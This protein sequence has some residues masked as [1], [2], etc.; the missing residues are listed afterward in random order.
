MKLFYSTF[1]SIFHFSQKQDSI[2]LIVLSNSHICQNLVLNAECKIIKRRL[3][4]CTNTE[5]ISWIISLF[6]VHFRR[7]HVMVHSFHECHIYCIENITS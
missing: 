6:L 5:F 3:L 1:N 7:F 4:L 2:C